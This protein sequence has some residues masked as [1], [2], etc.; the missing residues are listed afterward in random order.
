MNSNND[1][2]LRTYL[3]LKEKLLTLKDQAELPDDN[4]KGNSKED[5]FK[6]I[7]GNSNLELKG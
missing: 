2:I 6:N 5:I 3:K 1:I 4:K 7:D